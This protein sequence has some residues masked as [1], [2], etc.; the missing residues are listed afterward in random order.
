MRFRSLYDPTLS[1][2]GWTPLEIL[3]GER[4]HILLAYAEPRERRRVKS[5]LEDDGC[6]VTEAANGAQAVA[7]LA[8]CTVTRRPLP[9]LMVA[10]VHLDGWNGVELAAGLRDTDWD[11]PIVLIA[12]PIAEPGVRARAMREGVSSVFERSFDP[13]D[14]RT[15]LLHVLERAR[16]RRG[17]PDIA[18]EAADVAEPAAREIAHGGETPPA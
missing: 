9:T 5:F 10:G 15:A 14:F 12:D 3:C 1:T 11:V 17:T 16:S 8:H 13:N 6:E 7:S 4:P 2:A 18:V